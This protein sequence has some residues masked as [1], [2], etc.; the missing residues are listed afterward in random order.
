MIKL[1]DL[2]W[3]QDFSIEM[4]PVCILS[5]HIEIL[6]QLPAR[7]FGCEGIILIVKILE[8]FGEELPT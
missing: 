6:C 5:P 8:L 3:G 2:E 4:I 1:L 7:L